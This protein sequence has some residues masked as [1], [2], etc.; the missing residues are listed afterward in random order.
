MHTPRNLRSLLAISFLVGLAATANAAGRTIYVDDDGPADFNTIQA[1]INDCNNGDVVVVARGTYFEN[2]NFL[3]KNITLTGT[4]PTDSDTV[5]NTIIS[6][7]VQFSGTEGP[8]C[9]LAGFNIKRYISG[10]PLGGSHTH[11]AISHCVLVGNLTLCEPAIDR[12]DGIISNCVI[13]YNHTVCAAVVAGIRACHGLIRNC[14]IAHNPCQVRV[15][16]PGTCTMENCI[17]YEKSVWCTVWVDKG[18]TAS[19][20]HS[21]VSGGLAGIACTEGC[22]LNWGP[23]NTDVEPLFAD[24]VDPFF[25]GVASADFH[26]KS[27][28]GRWDPNSQ[29]WVTDDVTSPCIDAGDPMNPIG[30]EPFPNA[31]VINMGAYGATA[32]ASKS[33]F[34]EPVC[35]TIVAGDIN[36]DCRVDFED[37]QLMASHWLEHH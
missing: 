25:T 23:A 24:D 11:A 33:Y 14:T 26:V 10:G 22:I 27:Q 8:H 5:H 34:G 21:N 4:H 18:A 19:I 12:C 16:S 3:G 32:E 9:T 17:I 7:I 29:T 13:A 31:G 30:L 1:A 35:L 2:V 36:G 6:G 28:A 20:L 15:R 37:F